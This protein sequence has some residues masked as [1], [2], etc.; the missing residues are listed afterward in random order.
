MRFFIEFS[1]KGT[2]YHGWQVQPNA[3]T[4]QAEINK[5]LS[6]IL[7]A[8]I[9]VAGA[10]RTDAGVHAKQ[11]F[12]HFD[13]DKEFD[14]HTTITKL[15]S[16]L[17]NDIA[18]RSFFKVKEATSSRFDALSRIYHYNIVQQKN[19]FKTTA[20]FVHKPLDVKQ[21][22]LACQYLL[23]K[24]DF[25]SFSKANTQTFTNNCNVIL[26]N[27]QW[28]DEELIFTIKADRFLR[29]MVRA[30]VG[31]LLEVGLGKIKEGQVKEIIAQ[32]DRCMAGASVPANALFL[33][34]IEYPKDIF[35]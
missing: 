2:N 7:N 5:A 23:G 14:F 11:M 16:F 22:N 31:T 8:K 32:R 17:A 26:A 4:V 9:E 19:P 30:I 35:L 25:T 27:W 13:Y 33:N 21:M 34:E 24:Q 1:Y 20:Y 3:N 12:A 10:G 15:N 28:Q 6:C 18:V 29:N